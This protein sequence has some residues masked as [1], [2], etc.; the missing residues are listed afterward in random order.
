MLCDRLLCHCTCINSELV[1]MGLTQ[2]RNWRIV[3][4]YTKCLIE[5]PMPPFGTP[6]TYAAAMKPDRSGSSEKFSK[7]S[8]MERKIRRDGSY[9]SRYQTYT[10]T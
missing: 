5:V 1:W 8:I 7:A 6:L 4:T 3:G 9:H 10:A 2:D